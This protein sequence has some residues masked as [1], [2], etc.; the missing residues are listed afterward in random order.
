MPI[1]RLFDFFAASSDQTDQSEAH[2]DAIR[3]ATAAVLLEV[4]HAGS[5]TGESEE[6]EVVDHLVAAFDLD[7]E[8]AS[9]LIEAAGEIKAN[10]IDH[11]ELTNRIRQATDAEE[12]MAMVR[13]MWRIVYADGRFNQYE[14]YLVRKLSDLMGVEHSRMIEAKMQIRAELG[15]ED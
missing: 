8:G 10:T 6:R 14:G 5:E 2:D 3:L 12:R 13:S 9:D 11:F 15:L 7:D 4:A 1:G